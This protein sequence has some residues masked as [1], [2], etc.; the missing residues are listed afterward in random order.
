MYHCQ[1]SDSDPMGLLLVKVCK[2]HQHTR[3][4]MCFALIQFKFIDSTSIGIVIHTSKQCHH[5]IN[6]NQ[7]YYGHDLI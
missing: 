6:N 4:F 1:S 5:F 2:M 3:T 7:D